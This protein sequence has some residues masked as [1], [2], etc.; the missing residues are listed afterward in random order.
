MNLKTTIARLTPPQ[1]VSQTHITTL[2]ELSEKSL[3]AVIVISILTAIGV[4]KI[5]FIE[6]F[7][8][9]SIIIFIAL[10]RLKQAKNFK[11]Y[12]DK[13]TFQKWY[14]TF[15]WS[16]FIMASTISVVGIIFLAKVDD[17]HQLFI[18][19]ISI[20][21]LA[22]GTQVLIID[23]Y[24][25]IV[26]NSIILIPMM[27]GVA[28]FQ[29]EFKIILPL[30]IISFFLS[31]IMIIYQYTAKNNK[32]DALLEENK[33][34]I[35][36]TVHQIRTPLTVIMSNLSLIEL[37]TN[38]NI[39]PYTKQIHASIN[40]LSNSYEDLSYWLSHDTIEYSRKKINLSSLLKE[41]TVFF[42]PI[43]EVNHKDLT[44]T[45][46]EDISIIANAIEIERII[47]N[48][49]SNA[50]KHSKDRSQIKVLLERNGSHILLQF[51]SEGNPIQDKEKIFEKHY[52]ENTL[53]K[54]NLGLGLSMV[55]EICEKNR[56]AYSITSQA[57]QN[58]FTYRLESPQ[59]ND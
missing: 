24:I 38:D 39:L 21:Y 46:E 40:L 30:L 50:I 59:S 15:L 6:G 16:A 19:S 4:Y 45:I 7:L 31:Q 32:I 13:H 29:T 37:K 11:R 26:Y 57:H 14:K 27:I 49:L 48:N 25:S 52:S 9:V 10:L 2:Y 12:A 20:G 22:G 56:I 8:W 41:R 28:L 55:K 34:F 18:V 1:N 36:D 58:I 5:L 42:T 53:S 54:R 35:G 3:L 17:L 33:R 44:Q 51:I 43:A 23:R 47:D